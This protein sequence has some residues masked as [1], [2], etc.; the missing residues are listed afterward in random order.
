[1]DRDGIIV[2]VEDGN[3]S[4]ARLLLRDAHGKGAFPAHHHWCGLGL[5]VGA[6]HCIRLA[7]RAEHPRPG[8]S[9]PFG[10]AP[11]EISTFLALERAQVG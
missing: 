1:V 2:A 3:N 9:D 8:E 5:D 4:F 6:F 10:N 7:S 11:I